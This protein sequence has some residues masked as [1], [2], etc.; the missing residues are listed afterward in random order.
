MGEHGRLRVRVRVGSCE[1]ADKVRS[2][3]GVRVVVR[4]RPC[5]KGGR[6]RERTARTFSSAIKEPNT[7]F[8]LGRA[9]PWTG[10]L[11]PRS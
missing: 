10:A 9:R 1:E 11:G 3:V 6:V 7:L 4:S 2:G 8:V 5:E